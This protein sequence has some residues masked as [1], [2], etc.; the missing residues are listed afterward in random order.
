M[1]KKELDSSREIRCTGISMHNK[2]LFLTSDMSSNVYRL[3]N[4]VTTWCN[5]VCIEFTGHC[6]VKCTFTT[7]ATEEQFTNQHM[8]RRTS[9]SSHRICSHDAVC[10]KARHRVPP[11]AENRDARDSCMCRVYANRTHSVCVSIKAGK[12]QSCVIFGPGA[13]QSAIVCE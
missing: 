2:H 5:F 1:I 3:T 6:R 13:E 12:R 9:L 10:R 7:Y 8:L 11:L 4:I